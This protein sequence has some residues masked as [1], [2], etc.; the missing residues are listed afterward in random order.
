MKRFPPLSDKALNRCLFVSKEPLPEEIEQPWVVRHFRVKETGDYHRYYLVIPRARLS[1]FLGEP[2]SVRNAACRAEAIH[3]WDK[4]TMT[5]VRVKAMDRLIRSA[6]PASWDDE[7]DPEK[8]RR[9]FCDS[10]CR[11]CGLH[12]A[13]LGAFDQHVTE[14]HQHPSKSDYLVPARGRNTGCEIIG[15]HYD[16]PMRRYLPNSAPTRSYVPG[17]RIW[18]HVDAQRVR[19]AFS[20]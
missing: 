20:E 2:L 11:L 12:F 5:T 1:N 15:A 9:R 4:Q 8:G 17:V 6:A 19:K 13:S 7:Y 18:E 14:R 10:H 16:S 3:S